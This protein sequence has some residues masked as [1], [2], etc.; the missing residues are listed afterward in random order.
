M[1]VRELKSTLR[2]ALP[3][4]AGQ[5]GQMVMGLVDTLMVGRLGATELAAASFANILIWIPLVFGMGLM[6][7]VSMRVSQARGAGRPER[8][9]EALGHGV[10]LAAAAGVVLAG[11]LLGLMP[12]LGRF[13]QP[14]EVV[15]AAPVF[16]FPVALSVVPALVAMALKNYADAME[17]PWVAFWITL[18]GIILN[19]L[20]NWILIFGNLGVPALG[21]AGAGWATAIA[22][23]VTLIALFG[24]VA[25][26]SAFRLWR[27][28]R[29]LFVPRRDLLGRLLVL[30]A[31]VSLGLLTEVGAFGL[32]GLM[33]GW[34]STTAL[35]A[36]QIA[37]TCA[38]FTFMVPLGLSM[39]TT[40]RVGHCHGSRD[41]ERMRAVAIGSI[42]AGGGLMAISATIFLIF[43][44]VISGWFINDAEVRALAA[45]LL[46]IAGLFQIFDGLQVAAS[47]VLRGLNDVRWPA[48]ICLVAYWVV[49]LPLAWLAAFGFG[50]RAEGVWTGLA[51]G[52]AVAAAALVVRVHRHLHALV[53]TTAPR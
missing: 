53:L 38:S 46:I 10:W 31:P 21:L 47:G 22:R 34:I 44:S 52:L 36:H 45:R 14:A 12:W 8:A 49:A 43:G 3:L 13:G 29:W 42:W 24:W 5:V 37:L 35:A 11:G 23:A 18:G 48:L 16:Y 25:R 7:A 32:A 2:L 41:H 33:T 26:A 17:R 39:A 4:M 1:I 9:A 20:L 40:V 50:W 19:I 27:P 15:A 30:G 51:L 6:V 28:S